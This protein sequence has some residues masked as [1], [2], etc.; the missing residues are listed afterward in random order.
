[1]LYIDLHVY[2]FVQD[3]MNSLTIL[4]Q[5]GALKYVIH[6]KSGPGPMLITDKNESLIGDNGLP[7]I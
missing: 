6:T 4:P 2:F 3:D 1:V 5:N 7:K